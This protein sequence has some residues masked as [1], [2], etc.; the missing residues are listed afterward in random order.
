MPPQHS[1]DQQEHAHLEGC[2]KVGMT[3]SLVESA[4][5]LALI[6]FDVA[7]QDKD[8]YQDKITSARMAPRGTPGDGC[9]QHVQW[10][11]LHHCEHS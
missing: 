2:P 1:D 9:F 7:Y 8:E 5:H 10:R 3:Q 6:G 11:F 4:S